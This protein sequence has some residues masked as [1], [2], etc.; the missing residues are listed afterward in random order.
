MSARDI[1]PAVLN[2]TVPMRVDILEAGVPG[3]DAAEAFIHSHYAQAY[4]ADV[5]HFLPRLMVLHA[6]DGELLATLGFRRARNERLFLEQYLDTPLE[7]QLALKL[8]YYCQRYEMVEVGNL[9]TKK[10][11]G[12]R[13]LIAAL[14]AY[15][16]AAGYEWAVFTAV[17]QLRNAFARLNVELVPLGPADKSRLDMQEQILW[18]KYYETDPQVVVA[19]VSQSY[20]ALLGY[21]DFESDRHRLKPLWQGAFAAGS[22]A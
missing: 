2:Q 9:A 11:G 5:R 3:R 20:E 4:G 21:L 13:W 19:S 16:K 12:A 8:G 14:T 7:T 22:A 18:G 6:A 17:R 15:L 1:D 10:P